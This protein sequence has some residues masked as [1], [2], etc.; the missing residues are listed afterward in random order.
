MVTEC[1]DGEG[2]DQTDSNASDHGYT[3]LPVVV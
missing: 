1:T 2:D 3:S